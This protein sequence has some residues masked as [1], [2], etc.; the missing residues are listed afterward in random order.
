MAAVVPGSTLH[1]LSNVGLDENAEQQEAGLFCRNSA[2]FLIIYSQTLTFLAEVT[3]SPTLDLR[4][5][6]TSSLLTSTTT[7]L[8]NLVLAKPAL[9]PTLHRPIPPSTVH[10][11]P[12]ELLGLVFLHYIQ[13][14]SPWTL[15]HVSRLWRTVAFSTPRLWAGVRVAGIRSREGSKTP[16][17][18]DGLEYCDSVPRLQSAL[19]RAGAVPLDVCIGTHDFH[20]AY[21]TQ[22]QNE[23]NNRTREALLEECFKMGVDNWR[24]LEIAR[25]WVLHFTAVD[26]M[27]HG[28]LANLEE[29]SI[30]GFQSS[31][32]HHLLVDAPRLTTV[33]LRHVS[34]RP[35]AVLPFWS[36]IR[37]LSLVKAFLFDNDEF[38]A[39]ATVLEASRSLESLQ[40]ELKDFHRP[41]W[42]PL[43]PRGPIALSSLRSLTYCGHW[44]IPIVAPNLVQLA[45]EDIRLPELLEA[46]HL[47]GVSFIEL[48]NLIR[49]SLSRT[50]LPDLA[51]LRAPR[52]KDLTLRSMMKPNTDE[53]LT[54]VWS[55]ET[56]DKP[57]DGSGLFPALSILRLEGFTA[58][59]TILRSALESLSPQLYELHFKNCLLPRTFFRVFCSGP[60]RRSSPPAS[61]FSASAA[62]S[63]QMS[64][65]PP[66]FPLQQ[67]GYLCPILESMTIVVHEKARAD[68]DV[69]RPALLDIVNMRKI[70]GLNL[71][72]LIVDWD[73]SGKREELYAGG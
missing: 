31:A 68:K 39:F 43:H 5:V 4:E 18:S 60:P 30:C 16:R 42:A 72:T 69:I 62:S 12:F 17:W 57:D 21:V 63:A 20:H 50:I 54:S 13:T 28:R 26:G 37:S 1:A 56:R 58:S 51:S 7:S 24:S 2:L 19:A 73:E 29:L 27:L 8:S 23:Q 9:S 34:L 71:N 22:E 67:T 36:Q 10:M 3:T 64:H 45:I 35:Y 40:I 25:C 6:E 61:S 11:L 44:A 33:A 55:H 32:L 41:Q 14:D 66:P 65:S 53:G 52:L 49:L 46:K 59:F 70:A 38:D 48:P 15:T 47:D